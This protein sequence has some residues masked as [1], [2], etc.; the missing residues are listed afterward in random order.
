MHQ[1]TGWF[2]LRDSPGETDPQRQDEV[3]REV[4]K[5]I[6]DELSWLSGFVEMKTIDG[7]TLVTITGLTNHKGVE[8]EEVDRLLER[9]CRTAPRSFGVLHDWDDEAT[10]WPG[11]QAFMVRVLTRGQVEV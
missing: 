10:E 6:S 4:G 3:V 9:I 7:E 5:F 11:P 2:V 8:A 1:F